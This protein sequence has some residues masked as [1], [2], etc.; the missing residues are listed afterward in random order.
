RLWLSNAKPWNQRVTADA[1]GVGAMPRCAMMRSSFSVSSRDSSLD[2]VKKEAMLRSKIQIETRQ[3]QM[4]SRHP[5]EWGDR[6]QID[7]KNEWALLPP[8]DP[9]R[10]ADD[11]TAMTRE[12][13][14][15]PMQPPPLVYR[16][17]EPPEGPEPGGSGW[18]LRSV[19]V[20]DG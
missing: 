4:A 15:P 12:L 8:E 11:R 6:Q 17:E 7:V 2:L 3:W 20:R 19:T 9:H 5:Q 16:W 10:R 14:K 18:Q 13:N 1:E